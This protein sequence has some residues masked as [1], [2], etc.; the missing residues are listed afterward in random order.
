MVSV[1]FVCP[2]SDCRSGVYDC[3]SLYRQKRGALPAEPASLAE[4]NLTGKWTTTGPDSLEPFLIYDSWSAAIDRVIVFPP[5]KQ[6]QRLA[7][8]EKWFMDG[9]YNMS[10]RLFKQLYI[11]RVL[12]G[13]SAV[14]CAYAIL[15]G[16][17]FFQHC[18]VIIV[19]QCTTAVQNITR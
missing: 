14:T 17:T 8:A 16:Q 7:Y 2:V 6:L 10:L 15:T 11:I 5:R 19:S 4:L 12:L 3:C 9:Y 13:S 18:H 1:T